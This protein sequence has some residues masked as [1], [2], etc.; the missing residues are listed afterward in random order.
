MGAVRMITMLCSPAVTLVLILPLPL[1]TSQTNHGPLPPY[2]KPSQEEQSPHHFI[3]SWNS[4]TI[5]HT[6]LQSSSI[7]AC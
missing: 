7:C 4:S 5:A 2:S 6:T 1:F 3:L